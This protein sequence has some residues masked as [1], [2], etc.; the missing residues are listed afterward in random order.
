MKTFLPRI[1][2]FFLLAALIP[3]CELLDDCK[4]CR[5]VTNDNGTLSYGTSLT[6]C[7]DKLAEIE[8]EDPETIGNTTTYWECE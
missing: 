8:A 2:T 6:Y 3:S 7:G 4:S 1:G 5:I